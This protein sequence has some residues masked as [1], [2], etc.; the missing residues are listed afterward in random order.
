MARSAAARPSVIAGNAGLLAGVRRDSADLG[1]EVQAERARS[2]INVLPGQ[3]QSEACTSA[4]GSR[5]AYVR[6][7]KFGSASG[8]WA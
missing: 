4:T 1:A 5:A 6:C 7:S 3:A 2:L 8:A